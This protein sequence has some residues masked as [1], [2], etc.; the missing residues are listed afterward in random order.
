MSTHLMGIDMKL[1]EIFEDGF[2]LVTE[3]PNCWIMDPTSTIL[4]RYIA[5]LGKVAT[6]REKL[7]LLGNIATL[8]RSCNPCLLRLYIG[9][10]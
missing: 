10:I 3:A 8:G 9:V 2:T 7:Q 4:E 1:W 6:L 5:T